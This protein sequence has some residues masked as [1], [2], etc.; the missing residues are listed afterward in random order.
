MAGISKINKYLQRFLT[1]CFL[2]ASY[3]SL[4]NVWGRHCAVNKMVKEEH[5]SMIIKTI[6][7]SYGQKTQK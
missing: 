7:Y 1:G 3:Y 2:T 6:K 4:N 5:Y